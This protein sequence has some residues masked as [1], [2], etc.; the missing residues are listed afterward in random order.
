MLGLEKVHNSLEYLEE[1][2]LKSI[3]RFTIYSRGLV[4]R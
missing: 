2:M 1:Q 4:E 3:V